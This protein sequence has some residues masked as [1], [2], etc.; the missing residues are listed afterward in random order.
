[1]RGSQPAVVLLERD[2]RGHVA[3]ADGQRMVAG[4]ERHAAVGRDH[5]EAAM[6]E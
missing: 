2:V 5:H 1:M 3:F 4:P 6:V